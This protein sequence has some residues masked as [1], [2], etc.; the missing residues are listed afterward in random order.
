MQGAMA[1]PRWPDAMAVGWQR[2][3]GRSRVFSCWQ[4]GQLSQFV[5]VAAPITWGVLRPLKAAKIARQ[6]VLIILFP[7][8]A[9]APFRLSGLDSSQPGVAVRCYAWMMQP[10]ATT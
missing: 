2:I 10:V 8:V 9:H 4:T 6:Q 3:I 5:L 7:V 1:A